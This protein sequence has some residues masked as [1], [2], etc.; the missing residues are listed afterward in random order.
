MVNTVNLGETEIK[1]LEAATIVFTEKGFEGTRMQDI[2]DKAKINKAL[3]HY[4]YRNKEKLFGEVFR[5]V[6]IQMISKLVGEL[7]GDK[8][9]FAKIR[10]FFRE[11]QQILLDNDQLPLFILSE[12]KRNPV[13]LVNEFEKLDISIVRLDFYKQIEE[14]KKRGIIRKDVQPLFLVLNMMSLSVFPFAA[15]ELINGVLDLEK[16]EFN[17]MI[18]YQKEQLG[19]FVINAIK[20]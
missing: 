13:L 4:Y 10:T 16:T 3:L 14:E 18:E 2:A 12:I 9:V 5:R 7:S 17:H 1:I 20:K 19:E 8:S 15:R 11:H 6:F